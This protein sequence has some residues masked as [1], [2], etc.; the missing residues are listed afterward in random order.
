M[1]TALPP[2][3]ARYTTDEGKEYF[4][5]A[6]T[7]TTQWDTPS[8]PEG[9]GGD[10]AEVFEYKPTAS[11]LEVKSLANMAALSTTVGSTAP[12]A[13]GASPVGVTPSV[14]TELVSLTAPTGKIGSGGAHTT[15][16]TSNELFGG[17]GGL[18]MMAMGASSSDAAS[19]SGA[20]L[21]SGISGWL[22]SSAQRLFDVSTDDVLQRLRLVLVPYPPPPDNGAK[23]D[24]R[25]R[26]D[27]YGPFWVATTA[28]LFLAATGNFAR[29]V[30]TGDHQNFKADYSLVSLAAAMVYG[31]LI[32]VPLIA[33][34]SLFISGEEV[35]SV[36]FR[37]MI[38]IC[39][40]SL[41]PTIPASMLCIV[42]W[43][44]FRWLMVLAGLALSLFFLRGNIFIDTAVKAAW[45]KWTMIAA[46]CALPAVVF[47]VY[48]VHF[49]S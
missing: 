20:D 18:G 38:C 14:T 36:D 4:H 21:N 5:N 23:E 46:P 10:H 31:C 2:G 45:L 39:G 40:Y 24:L 44:G 11:D 35:T 30:E 25:N 41:A 7:N 37:Q 34:A 47:F 28:V 6:A 15:S 42:P 22:L 32:A 29:L 12:T 27:F 13:L 8:W 16:V 48:R 3:W 19:S 33:R 43:S 17:I 26:P 49:F 9:V 1:S